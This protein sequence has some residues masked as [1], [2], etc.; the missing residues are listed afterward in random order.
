MDMRITPQTL[1]DQGFYN[2]QTQERL[3]V[4]QEQA[5]TGEKLLQ[6][7][8]NPLAMVTVLSSQAQDTRLGTYIANI[9]QAT[10]IL[11]DSVSNLQIATAIFQQANSLAQ[12]GA[13]AGND[14]ASFSALRHPGE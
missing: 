13:N 3:A 12:Q 9:Q 7:S 6:P 10:S 14:A 8:D 5:A 11:N 1:M 4:Y 2:T